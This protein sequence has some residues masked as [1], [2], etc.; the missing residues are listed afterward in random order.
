MSVRHIPCLARSSLL[1]ESLGQA[2]RYRWI[3]AVHFEGLLGKTAQ[4]AIPAGSQLTWDDVG[5]QAGE[6]LA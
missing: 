4:R 1:R 2:T 3:K 6:G 5:G